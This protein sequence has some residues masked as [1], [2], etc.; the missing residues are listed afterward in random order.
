MASLYG[1][2]QSIY[3]YIYIYIYKYTT[4][5]CIMYPLTIT[6]DVLCIEYYEQYIRT[7]SEPNLS[8]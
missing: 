2:G 3:I 7:G 1:N 5:I 6:K 4:I 8:L